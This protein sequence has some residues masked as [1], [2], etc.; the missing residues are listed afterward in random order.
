[1]KNDDTSNSKGNRCPFQ[2]TLGKEFTIFVPTSLKNSKKINTNSVV[3]QLATRFDYVLAKPGVEHC[4][5][6]ERAK[7][8]KCRR[9]L[10]ATAIRREN[11][12]GSEQEGD[13]EFIF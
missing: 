2:R 8:G 12:E 4:F 11:H 7:I 10:E 5:T 6:P 13:M 1:M 3:K 9:G